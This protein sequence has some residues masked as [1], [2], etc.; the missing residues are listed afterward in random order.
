MNFSVILSTWEWEKKLFLPGILIYLT[1]PM[2]MIYKQSKFCIKQVD[3]TYDING[4]YITELQLCL[5]SVF[6][7]ENPSLDFF[8]TYYDLSTFEQNE[9]SRFLKIPDNDQIYEKIIGI[10]Q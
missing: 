1:S 4:G 7:L 6:T 5:P 3:Y 10:F 8:E 9:I 2:N